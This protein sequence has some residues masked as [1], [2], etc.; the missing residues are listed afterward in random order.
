MQ[1]M[2]LLFHQNYFT[3]FQLVLDCF[4]VQFMAL[5]FDQNYFTVF[6]SILALLQCNLWQYSLIKI[7]L[8]YFN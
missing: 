2:A 7:V 3:V 1:F 4:M 5:Y 6:R 8:L